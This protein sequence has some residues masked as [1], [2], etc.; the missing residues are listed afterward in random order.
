MSNTFKIML[1]VL[2][3]VIVS[4]T[5]YAFAAANT[6]PDTKAGDGSG[7][8]SGYTI[9]N[10]AYGLNATDPTKL[11]SVTF[12]TS[13]A[14]LHVKIKLVNAGTDW[15]DCTSLNTTDWTCN[16]TSPQATVATMDKLTVIATSN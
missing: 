7:T 9:T 4:A 16:T 6:V 12:T 8:I 15:Y 1:I 2:V 10:V 11:D 14:A 3:V 5:A 13:A